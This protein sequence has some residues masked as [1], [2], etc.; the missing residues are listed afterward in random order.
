MV[1]AP[2]QFDRLHVHMKSRAAN[3]RDVCGIQGHVRDIAGWQGLW[4]WRVLPCN[5]TS[6]VFVRIQGLQMSE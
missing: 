4:R 5:S 3:V 2:L 6:H 1:V